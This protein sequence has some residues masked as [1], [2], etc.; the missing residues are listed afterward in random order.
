MYKVPKNSV[1]AAIPKKKRVT[2]PKVSMSITVFFGA[3]DLS[4]EH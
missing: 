2:P 1:N 3:G 4:L